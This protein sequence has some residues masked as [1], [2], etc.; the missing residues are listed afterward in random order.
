MVGNEDFSA[1]IERFCLKSLENVNQLVNFAPYS[2]EK[3]YK[4]QV[5]VYGDYFKKFKRTL[6]Q[7]TINKVYQVL[8]YIMTLDV[9]PQTYMK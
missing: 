5:T 1:G 4:R 3:E 2:N 6:Q 7:Q 8:L 9:I